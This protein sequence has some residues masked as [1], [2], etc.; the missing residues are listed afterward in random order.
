MSGHVQKRLVS[1]VS[2]LASVAP[3]TVPK[4]FPPREAFLAENEVARPAFDPQLWA[5]LQPVPSTALSA[6]A[7]RI[8]LG[9]VLHSEDDVR[10][11]CTHPTFVDVYRQHYPD[12]R[13]PRSNGQ[14][15]ALGNSLMGLFATEYLQAKYP[16][17]PT[18]V[19]KAALTAHVGPATCASVAQEMGAGQLLKWVRKVRF[20]THLLRKRQ[21]TLD[22][23]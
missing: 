14:L 6:F 16:Y 2:R 15:A 20:F 4:S 11:A 18:R 8:G 13:I 12:E 17:L 1:S 21:L 22:A 9:S 19:Q 7:H 23:A 3:S 10:Q 5:S